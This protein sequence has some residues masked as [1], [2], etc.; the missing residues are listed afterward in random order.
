MYL[1]E[2]IFREYR[3]RLGVIAEITQ[4]WSQTNWVQIPALS[5][6]IVSWLVML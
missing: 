3:K 5:Q 4:L 6:L 1:K 2:A